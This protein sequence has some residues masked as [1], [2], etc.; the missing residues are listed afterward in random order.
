MGLHLNLLGRGLLL[1]SRRRIGFGMDPH[2][3]DYL[4]T[5]QAAGKV[6]AR[7]E[8]VKLNAIA[9]YMR[10]QALQD[11]YRIVPMKS[12]QNVGSGATAHGFGGASAN[13]MTLFA[14]PAWGA[15]GIAF[16]GTSQYGSIPDFLGSE[17]ITVFARVSQASATPTTQNVIAAQYDTGA[18][19]RSWS[20]NH[21]GDQAGAPYRPYRSSNGLDTGLEIYTTETGL[22]STADR[23][24]VCQWVAG[25]GRSMW[26]DD[27]SVSLLL[28]SGTP[29][30]A[31][32]DSPAPITFCSSMNSGTPANFAALTGTALCIV[33]GAITDTQRNTLRALISAL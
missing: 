25:G 9:T 13:P 6:V 17:T 4:V 1:G 16:D 5:L 11:A 29:Q 30:T 8:A 21:R 26:F 12:A 24:L 7:A 31:R 18:N 15:D 28:S 19:H 14:S 20:I 10:S 2:I 32:F 23:V 3:R 27:T 33:R 22:G